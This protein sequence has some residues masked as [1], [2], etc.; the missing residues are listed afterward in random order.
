[1]YIVKYYFQILQNKL[2]KQSHNDRETL[3]EVYAE[4]ESEEEPT[5]EEDYEDDL[6]ELLYNEKVDLEKNRS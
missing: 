1:M 5:Y 6:D 3:E 4:K 2:A